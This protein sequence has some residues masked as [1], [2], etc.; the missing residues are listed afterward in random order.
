MVAERGEVEVSTESAQRPLAGPLGAKM[1]QSKAVFEVF[2][3]AVSE[4]RQLE[5]LGMV[6]ARRPRKDLAG[7]SPH[8]GASEA[9]R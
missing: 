6:L 3:G 1:R 8:D 4:Q 9:P 5:E 2:V 7:A